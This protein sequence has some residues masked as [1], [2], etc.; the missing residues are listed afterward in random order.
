MPSCYTKEK[1]SGTKKLKTESNIYNIVFQKI[2]KKIFWMILFFKVIIKNKKV[3]KKITK[4]IYHSWAM[5]YLLI[6]NNKLFK[7]FIMIKILLRKK[8]VCSKVTTESKI[9]TRKFLAA[10]LDKYNMKFSAAKSLINQF[11]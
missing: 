6:N 5:I 1:I 3:S 2:F 7:K 8:W 10:N 9:S 4:K 11:N